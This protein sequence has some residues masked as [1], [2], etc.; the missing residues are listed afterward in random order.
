VRNL[1]ARIVLGDSAG[2][3]VTSPFATIRADCQ[4]DELCVPP[5]PRQKLAATRL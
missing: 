5:Q 1:I 4:A 2:Y 3:A